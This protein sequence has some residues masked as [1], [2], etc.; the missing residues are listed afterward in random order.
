MEQILD[1]AGATL[2]FASPRIAGELARVT[3]VPVEI[4]GRPDYAARCA[5]AI[6]DP[7]RYTDPASLAWLFYT[8][9]TTG[10]RRAPCCRT[11]I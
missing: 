6:S 2:V 9:G 8:S 3:S 5:A 1:D 11:A 4:I 10:A 7:P